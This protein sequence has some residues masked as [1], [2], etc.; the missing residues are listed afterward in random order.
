M[1]IYLLPQSLHFRLLDFLKFLKYTHF[2]PVTGPLHT[3]SLSIWHASTF[4]PDPSSSITSLEKP[5]SKLLPALHRCC[6]RNAIFSFIVFFFFSFS[7]FTLVPI[8]H[9]MICCCF[10]KPRDGVLRAGVPHH[11]IHGNQPGVC[12]TEMFKTCLWDKSELFL[13]SAFSLSLSN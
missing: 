9:L 5:P 7:V 8:R 13:F 6:N 4:R 2:P 11:W 10:S 12:H 3:P 1:P